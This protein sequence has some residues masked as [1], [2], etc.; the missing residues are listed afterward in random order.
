MTGLRDEFDDYLAEALQDPEF[1]R[2]YEEAA[3]RAARRPLARLGSCQECY[4][5]WRQERCTAC[6]PGAFPVPVAGKFK[7]GPKAARVYGRGRRR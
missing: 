1:A 4:G 2:A 6:H 5:W 3:Q 7:P